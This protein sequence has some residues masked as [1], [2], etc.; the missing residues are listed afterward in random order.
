MRCAFLRDLVLLP[1]ILCSIVLCSAQEAVSVASCYSRHLVHCLHVLFSQCIHCVSRIL[2]RGIVWSTHCENLFSDNGVSVA[3]SL[4]GSAQHAKSV[5][6][7]LLFSPQFIWEIGLR[8]FRGNKRLAACLNLPPATSAQYIQQGQCNPQLR[9]TISFLI[10]FCSRVLHCLC[11][12]ALCFLALSVSL[13]CWSAKFL[14][15]LTD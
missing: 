13:D 11:C 15:R 6:T 10:W 2:M 9:Y 4:A 7:N 1:T 12:V 8:S 3:A 5:T 14:L